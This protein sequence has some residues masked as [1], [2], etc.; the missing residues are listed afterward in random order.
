MLRRILTVGLVLPAVAVIATSTPAG[1]APPQCRGQAATVVG[2]SGDDHL[3]GTPGDDVVVGLGGNDVVTGLGGDDVLC[4]GPGADD[5]V[6]GPGDDLVYGGPDER[7]VHGRRTFV[8]GDLLEGG[9]GDDVLDAGVD[10]L[11]G[12]VELRQANIVSFQHS[13]RAVT[14]DL[15][16]E[17]AHGEGDDVVVR[18]R[19]LEVDG[20]RYDDSLLGSSLA[21]TLDGG[22]GDD[23]LSG[24]GGADAVLDYHGD[25]ELRGGDGADLVISTAGTDTVGGGDGPDFLIAGS[26][27]PT[28]LLG[29]GGFD[30]LSRQ[31]KSGPTGV[32]DGGPGGGQLELDPQ[33]WFDSPRTAIL[34]AA[35]GTAVVTSAGR[36][37]T[38]DFTNIVAFT[39]WDTTWTF[40]GT[41]ADDFVQILEGRMKAKTLGGDDTMIGADGDDVLDGGDGTD[42]GWGGGGTNTCV[43][44]ESGSCTGYP[45]PSRT[46]RRLAARGPWT[47]LG[48][49]QPGD[50]GSRW[51]RHR[52]PAAVR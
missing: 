38:T 6:G 1:A 21:E 17:T 16:D 47:R 29:G 44:T 48:D 33:L 39:L 35:A 34:D 30:F 11:K 18:G 4:G 14:V 36:T 12:R 25:D 52:W 7:R 49:T 22:R 10:H 43:S 20:S 32:I 8:E 31:I 50:L 2:T 5:L 13:A 37:H 19:W 28:T 41:D 24:R 40:R 3:A 42:A 27:A 45:W 23:R 15:S 9:P 46:P 51:M 26:W